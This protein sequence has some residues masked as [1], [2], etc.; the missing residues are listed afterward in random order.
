MN[1]YE[2]G[3]DSIGVAMGQKNW[4][5]I[6]EAYRKSIVRCQQFGGELVFDMGK[7]AYNW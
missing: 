3:K 4:N 5:D 2:V 6:T 7:A 1:Q